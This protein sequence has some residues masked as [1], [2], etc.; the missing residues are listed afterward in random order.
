MLRE[1]VNLDMQPIPPARRLGCV[2]AT[3]QVTFS[4]VFP[5]AYRAPTVAPKIAPR[6]RV[7]LLLLA[8]YGQPNHDD[9]EFYR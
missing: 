7:L 4:R 2:D 3:I 9:F 5:R 1:D 6:R 8:L